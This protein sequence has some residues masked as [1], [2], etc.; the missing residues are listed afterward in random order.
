MAEAFEFSGP[1]DVQLDTQPAG[2]P[3]NLGRS[4]GEER[5][6]FDVRIFGREVSSDEDGLVPSEIIHLGMMGLLQ[7]QLVKWDRVQL[8]ALWNTIPRLAVSGD[9]HLSTGDELTGGAVGRLWS[10]TTVAAIGFFGIILTPD[11]EDTRVIRTFNKCYLLGDD[12]IR[13]AEIGNDKTVIRL[14]IHVLPDSNG[15][16][17]AKTETS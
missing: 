15:D 4:D 13:E 16:L 17:Y 12:A 11:L 9:A 10:T 3:T 1:T 6:S 14:S 5:I 2:S 7:M 8:Q